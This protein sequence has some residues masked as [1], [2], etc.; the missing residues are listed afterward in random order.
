MHGG[1]ENETPNIPTNSII[2]LDLMAHFKGNDMLISKIESA[3]NTQTKP[4]NIA[5]G[6]SNNNSSN[7]SNNS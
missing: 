5:G 7:N 2:K 3:F 6:K 1:F 4:G